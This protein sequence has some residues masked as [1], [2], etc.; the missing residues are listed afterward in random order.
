MFGPVTVL[1]LLGVIFCDGI[2]MIV[3]A[4]IMGI[5]AAV[6]FI[7]TFGLPAILAKPGEVHRMAGGMLTISYSIG[8]VTPIICGAL[9]DLSGVPWTAFIPM[10]LCAIGMT[11]FGVVLTRPSLK[12]PAA[13]QR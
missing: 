4:T 3:A 5:G 13:Q 6:T 11:V 10:V 2:W 1:G 7:V 9:W 8:V 12:Q